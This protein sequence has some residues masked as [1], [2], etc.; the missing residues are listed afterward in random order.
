MIAYFH[1]DPNHLDSDY[2]IDQ[3]P[4]IDFYLDLDV[5]VVGSFLNQCWLAYCR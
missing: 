1:L 4:S 5:E 3:C 2:W